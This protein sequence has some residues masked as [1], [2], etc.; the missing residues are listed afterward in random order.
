MKKTRIVLLLLVML[1]MTVLMSGCLAIEMKINP[2]GS[3]DMTYTIDMSQL[4]GM[5]TKEQL[6]D[7]IKQSVTDMNDEAGKEIAKLKGIKEDKKKETLSATISITDLNKM[8]DGTYYGTVKNYIKEDGTGLDMLVKPGKDKV[9]DEDDIPI[10]SQMVYLPMN[11]ADEFGAIEITVMVPGTIQYVTEGGD[12][13][14][15]TAV[16]SSSSPLVVYKKGGSLPIIPIL[17]VILVIV[18]VI[19]FLGKKKTPVVETAPMPVYQAPEQATVVTPIQAPEVDVPQ[20][21]EDAPEN[22]PEN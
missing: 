6:E 8:G 5:M 19:A 13:K 3:C 20:I 2:N 22:T 16:F 9:V 12:V 10:N 1:M 21:I 17:L 18:L 15:K 11:G 14:G 7:S 4:E